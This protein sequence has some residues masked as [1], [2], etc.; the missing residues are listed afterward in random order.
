[1]KK[2]II[3]LVIILVVFSVWF[4]F[5]YTKPIKNR[6]TVSDIQ[7][8]FV[9]EYDL[10]Q[11]KLTRVWDES[12]CQKIE[13][14]ISIYSSMIQYSICNYTIN[15][16]NNTWVIVELKKFTNLEDLN[17]TYQYDS[18][19][20][21]GSKGLISENDYGDQSRFRINSDDDYGAQYNE[22]GIYY[23]HLW[24]TKDLY[25]IHITSK[26]SIDA[27]EHI[28]KIGEQILSKFG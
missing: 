20:L 18:S 1:M 7:Q 17:G 5:Q 25:L 8:L 23:Y 19:H 22:P 12:D 26:G 27:R 10:Q 21:Y 11:L 13:E 14:Q 24:I 4:I 2:I 15:N 9:N 3:A 16:L 28:V 6:S